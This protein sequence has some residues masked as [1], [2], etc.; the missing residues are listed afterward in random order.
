[1]AAHSRKP[2]KRAVDK[3]AGKGSVAEKLKKHR[4]A[5]ESGDASGGKPVIGRKRKGR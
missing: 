5:L 2:S 4:Q 1:M 3:L